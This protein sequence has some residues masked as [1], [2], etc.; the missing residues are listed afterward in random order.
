[1]Q[2]DKQVPKIGKRCSDGECVEGQWQTTFQ[3]F[4]V[5]VAD[6]LNVRKK[7]SISSGIVVQLPLTRKVTI[8]YLAPEEV[9]IGTKKGRWAYVRDTKNFEVTG[10]I[11]DNFLGYTNNFKKI[12]GWRIKY[13]KAVLGSRESEYFCL[14]AGSC[15][16]NWSKGKGKDAKKGKVKGHFYRF[17]D[18]IWFKKEK[19][20]DLVDLFYYQ[21]DRSLALQ[22]Q[23]RKGKIYITK[24]SR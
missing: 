16:K 4:A 14:P 21:K 5:V 22:D 13:I 20:D 8:L 3:R 6:G 12:P 18:V 9:V 2:G 19:P 11:F 17:R 23:Y 15:M 24:F 7:P 10:W 1:M